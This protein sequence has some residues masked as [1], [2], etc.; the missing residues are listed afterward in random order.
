MH[1]IRTSV[2][3][4]SGV[5]P[6]PLLY[7]PRMMMDDDE[8]G[9]IGGMSGKGNRTTRRKPAPLPLCPSH[10]LTRTRTRATAVGIW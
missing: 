2:N 9:A 10:N 7:E 6:S 4:W 5:E 3:I 8:C 1:V